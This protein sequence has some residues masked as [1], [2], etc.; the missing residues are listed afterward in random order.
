M[1]IKKQKPQGKRLLKN[2]SLRTKW[3]ICSILGLLLIGF[4]L[5]VFSEAGN[6]KHTNQATTRWVLL[7]TYSLILINGGLCIFGQAI[8]FRAKIESKKLIKKAL[9]ERDKK[10]KKLAITK[11]ATSQEQD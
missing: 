5:S 1:E 8:V 7:G 3:I 10:R 2:M 6:L 4:G 11:M 9:K